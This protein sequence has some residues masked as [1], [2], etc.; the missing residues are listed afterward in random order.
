MKRAILAATVVACIAGLSSVAISGGDDKKPA[1]AAAADMSGMMEKPSPE[2][3]ALAKFVGKWE[4]ESSMGPGMTAKGT[5]TIKAM[6]PFW[7]VEDASFEMMGQQHY[8]HGMYGYD[9]SRKK[10]VSLWGDSGGSWPMVSD[11]ELDADGKTIHYTSEG[12]DMMDPS[13]RVTYKMSAGWADDDTRTMTMSLPGPDG[14]DVQFW[15][16]KAKRVK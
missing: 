15:T 2:H 11:G 6:G 10:Y 5:S 4:T 13:K 1:D 9:A 3:L 12:P 7:V 14:K 8:G 16:M